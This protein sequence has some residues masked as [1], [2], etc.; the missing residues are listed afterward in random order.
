MAR[1][2]RLNFDL[3]YARVRDELNDQP[4]SG[5]AFVENPFERELLETN[6]AR[7]LSALRKRVTAGTYTP[8]AIELCGAPKGGDLI[9]PAARIGLDDRVVYTAAVGACLRS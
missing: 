2:S 4:R 5:R 1:T 7:W 3:A 9:R 8:G 6:L